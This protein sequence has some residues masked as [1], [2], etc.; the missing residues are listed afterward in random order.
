MNVITVSNLG[1]AYKQYPNRWSRLIEWMLP[2]SKPRHHLHWVLKNIDFTISPGEAVGI[3]GINGAGKSTLLK[4]ITGTAQPTT[5]HVQIQGKVA[6]L[7]ELGMGFHPDFTGRQ[8]ALMA[9]QML[10]YQIDQMQSL[11]SEIEA[12]AEI[13]EYMDQPVRVYSSGMQ[14]R[15]AFAVATAVRPDILIVDEALSVGDA[16]FQQKS[17]NR[18]RE[19]RKKGTSLLL[20][21]HDKQAIQSIC[22]KAILLN[23]GS[24][25]MQ[26]DPM[27]IMDYYNAIVNLR[28]N[29]TTVKQIQKG[30]RIETSS[31]NGQMSITAVEMLNSEGEH[32]EYFNFG[33]PTTLRIK[34]K[35]HAFTQ[36]L[37][38]GFLIKDRL[39]Q[40]VYGTNTDLLAS[41]LNDIQSDDEV[42]YCFTFDLTIGV[43]TYSIS[44]A[45]ASDGAVLDQNYFWLDLAKIFEVGDSKKTP[46]TGVAWLDT[47]VEIH[48]LE[49]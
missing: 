2:L 39:G 13:G 49:K 27:A 26:G 21:S 4:M 17:F 44:I 1:K 19:Y 31:G 24:I 41:Q 28:Q 37:I 33:A 6:A 23:G 48:R 12:F 47:A 16:Y 45:L 42:E 8:N 43:G 40:S 32:S 46:F 20:V 35:A 3:I 22:D 34:V 10:G 5:G 29:E 7:L 11:M 14:V 18:I 15:L 9:G 38:C 30:K 25:A 36:R